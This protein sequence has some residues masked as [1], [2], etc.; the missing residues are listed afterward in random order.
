MSTSIPLTLRHRMIRASIVLLVAA[1]GVSPALAQH[2]NQHD[3]RALAEDPRLAQGQLA[4]VLE[5]LGEN[6]FKVTT[7]SERAQ[8]FFDQGLKL[9]YGFNHQEALRS[10]KEVARL[11]PDCAMAYWGWALV[12]GPNLNLPMQADV[13]EQAHEAIQM[14][15]AR[16]AKVSAKEQALI[17]A[18]AERYSDDPEADRAALDR[19]YAQEMRDVH[20]VYA[21]DLDIATLYAAS[22]MNL[23]PWSYWSKDGEPTGATEDIV[24]IL[25]SVIERD[26]YHEGAL[27]YYIHAVEAVDAERGEQA[28]DNLRGLVPGI[29]HMMHMPSHIYMQVGRYADA[30]EANE[31]AAKA[32][33]GYI[34]QCRAQGIYPLNY[35]PH[36]VHFLAWAAIMQGKSE[37]A[38]AS[39]HKVAKIVPH[40]QHGDVWGLYQTFLSMPLYTMVRFGKWD[41]ILAS[42][43]PPSE[44]RYFSGIGHYARGMAYLHKGQLR[45]ARRELGNLAKLARA[46]DSPE[47]LVG[48]SNAATL[49]GIAHHVLAGELD[50]KRGKMEEALGHLSRAVR[51]E[52]S[53]LYNEPPDWYYPVRHTLGAV[54]LE[55][56]SPV[57]AEVVYWQDLEKHEENGYALY[58]LW[59]ALKAQGKTDAA[60]EIKERFQVAWKDAD[61]PLESSR[62]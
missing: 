6:H 16:K 1:L 57:E 55:S 13:V 17:D 8:R 58:G 7:R 18:L 29:G 22:L 23:S 51:L 32:D 46:A 50:A 53:L 5:G 11:D 49:L 40:D 39:S 31:L 48:F 52:D 36:N 44:L 41:E 33:E 56:G 12:L 37:S 54:L 34:T 21:D 15:V 27:H 9:T 59:Q 2:H 38:I 28:A 42:E 25:E 61:Q 62:F 45:P 47:V 60:A 10:F 19:A 43:P 26:K 20:D 14:A 3:P 30:Y 24:R 35:Y 4:P